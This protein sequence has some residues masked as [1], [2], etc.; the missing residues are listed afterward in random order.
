MAGELDLVRGR[1]RPAA[2][3]PR[4]VDRSEHGGRCTSPFSDPVPAVVCGAVAVRPPD[5][6]SPGW[7]GCRGA[8]VAWLRSAAVPVEVVTLGID[9]PARG[10][11]HGLAPAT[12]LHVAVQPWS[13]RH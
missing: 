12:G 13:A 4:G 6:E 1:D 5:G 8:R 11:D 10:A 9:R 7:S 3:G 2:A